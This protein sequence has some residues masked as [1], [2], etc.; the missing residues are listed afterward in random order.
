MRIFSALALCLSLACAAACGSS[1]PAPA[2]KPAAP[3]GPAAA[4]KSDVDEVGEQVLATGEKLAATINSAG[5]DC[6]KMG[7]ALQGIAD[8]MI[9]ASRLEQKLEADPAKKAEYERKY[10]GKFEALA[11][12]S[13]PKLEAC[14]TDPGVKAFIDKLSA[15]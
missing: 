2:P 11:K 10:E 6:A 8:D 3:A 12:D 1:K 13:F 7:Q 15:D 5:G 9:A 14:M 4:P